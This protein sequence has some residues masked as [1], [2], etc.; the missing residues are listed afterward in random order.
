MKK[1]FSILRN[2]GAVLFVVILVAV[3]GSILSGALSFQKMEYMVEVMKGTLAPP[4]PEKAR[5]S[6]DEALSEAE[7]MLAENI[8]LCKELQKKMEEVPIETSRYTS[9]LATLRSSLQQTMDEIDNEREKIA[10]DK[11]AFQEERDKFEQAVRDEGFAKKLEVI[12]KLD[13]EQTA[14]TIRDWNDDEI[15]RLFMLIKSSKLG[16]IIA[17]LNRF[18]AK[19]G[20]G[21][22]GAELLNK[23]DKYKMTFDA[24]VASAEG[25]TG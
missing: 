20:Q 5:L 16:E 8:E 4:P 21:T 3:V 22:R 6:E 18:P 2:A 15:I 10:A 17:E 1:I 14:L 13:A 23:L 19:Q 24:G 11:K 7:K 12:G 9:Y 25:R